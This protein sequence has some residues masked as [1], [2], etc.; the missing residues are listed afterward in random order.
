MQSKNRGKISAE[1]A[2]SKGKTPWLDAYGESRK[3]WRDVFFTKDE[4]PNLKKGGIRQ[5]NKKL[6]RRL[7]RRKW[8]S[9]KTIRKV[10][11]GDILP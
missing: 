3:H 10:I 8:N 1:F 11:H 9:R 5:P 2:I 4:S 7:K 6:A